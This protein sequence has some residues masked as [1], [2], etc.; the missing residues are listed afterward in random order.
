MLDVGYWAILERKAGRYVAH[1]PGLPGATAS[2]D[3]E[4]EVV[5]AL[6]EVAADRIRDR[7]EDGHVL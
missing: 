6:K 7:V 1:V 4:G 5:R 2:G 3:S